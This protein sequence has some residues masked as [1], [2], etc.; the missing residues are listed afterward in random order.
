MENSEVS[1]L[2]LILQGNQLDLIFYSIN[3]EMLPRRWEEAK[4]G[5]V[6]KEVA[7]HLQ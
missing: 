2:F 7:N 4:G 5:W 6:E 3:P 1:V